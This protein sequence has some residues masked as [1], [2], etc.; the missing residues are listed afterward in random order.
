MRLNKTTVSAAHS[1]PP[2]GH[3][4]PGL[5]LFSLRRVLCFLIQ[6]YRLV[7]SP[8]QVYLFGAQGGC[9]FTPTCSQYAMDAIREHGVLDGTLLAARR[10]C[11][12]HPF[13]EC[14]H[15]PVPKAVTLSK[16]EKHL[17]PC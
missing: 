10:I 16:T 14:G 9:R 2:A 15:D 6:T 8:A 3:V 1:E 4:Q 17:R 5:P 11:R 12:C 13:G 7:V